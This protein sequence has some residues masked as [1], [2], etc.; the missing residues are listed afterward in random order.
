[1]SNIRKC[2]TCDNDI[3]KQS[4]AESESNVYF[5]NDDCSYEYFKKQGIAKLSDTSQDK[6]SGCGSYTTQCSVCTRDLSN[7]WRFKYIEPAGKL[8][9][10]NDDYIHKTTNPTK[11]LFCGRDCY[12]TYNSDKCEEDDSAENKILYNCISCGFKYNIRMYEYDGKEYC[13]QQCIC[14][15][16]LYQK[17][18]I[19]G[20]SLLMALIIITCILVGIYFVKY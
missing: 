13:S 8:H 18:I 16:Y 4:C 17:L 2:I 3:S 19:I 20:L 5:C 9:L 15:R 10:G 1:M 11:L 6:C 12:Y 7:R 14:K